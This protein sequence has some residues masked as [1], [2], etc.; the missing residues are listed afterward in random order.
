MFIGPLPLVS[1]P[2]FFHIYT[3]Q[4]K[5][6]QA[7]DGKQDPAQDPGRT[8]MPSISAE[9]SARRRLICRQHRMD[10]AAADQPNTVKKK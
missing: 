3:Y 9:I 8:I 5:R 1:R 7:K 4:H 10:Q 6:I 2:T